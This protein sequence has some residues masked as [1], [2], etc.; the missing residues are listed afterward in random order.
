MIRNMGSFDRGVRAFGVAPVAIVLAFIAGVSTPAGVILF[1]LAGIML[2]TSAIGFCPNY[3]WLGIS[4]YPRGVH[5]VG[6]R[7]RHGH[8]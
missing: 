6:R 3:V 4:T 8:A 1:V 2:A 7:I 5:R